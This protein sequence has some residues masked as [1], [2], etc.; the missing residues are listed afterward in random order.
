MKHTSKYCIIICGIIFLIGVAVPVYIS[1]AASFHCPL[2][3][4]KTCESEYKSAG[5]A[6]RGDNAALGGGEGNI[7]LDCI[8]PCFYRC[9]KG[10][11]ESIKNCRKN[12]DQ[13]LDDCLYEGRLS[14]KMCWSLWQ[15]H[16]AQ[17]Y[18]K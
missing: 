1:N 7:Y 15:K 8:E 3:C 5:K 17:C 14:W 2:M 9:D 13:Q 6:S 11:S 16:I 18:Q 12:W 4:K 10:T